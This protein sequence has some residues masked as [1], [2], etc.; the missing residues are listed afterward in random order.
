VLLADDLG[1]YDVHWNNPDISTP[2]LEALVKDGALLDRHY[3]YK[4]CSP[5]RS[6]LLSGRLPI[7]VNEDNSPDPFPGAGIPRNLTI[8]AKKLKQAGYATH[9]VGKWHAGHASFGHIPTGRGFDTSLGYL[10]AAEDHW[11]QQREGCLGTHTDLWK[12]NGPAYGLNGTE[13]GGYLYNKEAVSIIQSHDPSTPLFLYMAFQNVHA[14]LEVPQPYINQYSSI[15]NKDRQVYSGMVAFL[16][17]AVGNI[18]N[19]LKKAGLW[20]NTLIVFS[21][22]NGGPTYAG[23]GGNNYPLKG[24]K[25][26]DWEG[27]VRVAAFVSGGFLPSAVRGTVIDGYVHVCDWYAT[28]AYLAG[29]D[30]TDNVPGFPA[31]DSINVWPLISGQTKTSPR[32]EIPLSSFPGV[33]NGIPHALSLISG[34]Y[35]LLLGEIP[36]SGWTG[37]QYP[38][39]TG[40]IVGPALLENCIGGCLYNI[41]EDP[42]E[43]QELSSQFPTKKLELI[44]RSKEILSTVYA[45]V[46][47]P[48]D[49]RACLVLVDTR[50][51]FSPW[52]E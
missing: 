45:P 51:F 33:L 27:G 3:V 34:P 47:G 14:P 39:N 22:D 17:E 26:S 24:G 1:H 9:Q 23:G 4:Y 41:I 32:T 18:T 7:H 48:A 50:G 29:V 20:E 37:P 6:S 36:I 5:T 30:P 31:T 11:T 10:A 49:V 44:A 15:D 12:N 35:K 42:T 43:H 16:D 2:N 13:Y 46:R 40:T 38:N 19:A 21:A 52:E 28:F 25:L 8:I